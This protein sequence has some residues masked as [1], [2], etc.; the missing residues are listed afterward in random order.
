MHRIWKAKKTT[1]AWFSDQEATI[2][3]KITHRYSEHHLEK[4]ESE[5]A[6]SVTQRER[7][8]ESP[9]SARLR[10][11]KWV[12]FVQPNITSVFICLW[13][14][15]NRPRFP[16]IQA[17]NHRNVEPTMYVQIQHFHRGFYS[18]TTSYRAGKAHLLQV[19]EAIGIIAVN[20]LVKKFSKS[21]FL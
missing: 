3:P 19:A 9:T 11:E 10:E 8:R 15:L 14:L 6:M 18:E 4:P 13:I 2:F 20:L 1:P 5:R 12:N 16:F 17:A 21:H 7:E